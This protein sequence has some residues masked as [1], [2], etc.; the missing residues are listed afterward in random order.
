MR[1]VDLLQRYDLL[2]QFSSFDSEKT[3]NFVLCVA[4][5]F[6][7]FSL[8]SGGYGVFFAV[9]GCYRRRG[10]GNYLCDCIKLSFI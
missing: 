5:F 4:L 2:W 3:R 6:S 7:H 10:V 1:H 8:S 9:T